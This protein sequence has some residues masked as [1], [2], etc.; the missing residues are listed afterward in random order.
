MAKKKK[1]PLNLWH[2]IVLLL[3]TGFF[4]VWQ[5]CFL[6]N[7]G[8]QIQEAENQHKEL[9]M[10]NRQLNTQVLSLKSASEIRQRIKIFNLPLVEP[11]EWNIYPLGAVATPDSK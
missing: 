3:T 9:T 10:E 5:Q 4:Y 11:K 7:L 1:K 8:Y 2:L 6:V